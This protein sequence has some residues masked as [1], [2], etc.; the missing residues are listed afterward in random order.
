MRVDD[1]SSGD[2]VSSLDRGD[3]H[4][5]FEFKDFYVNEL[6]SLVRFARGLAND[7]QAAEDIVAD[8]MVVVFK[9]W[10]D[11]TQGGDSRRR[12]FAF[13]VVKNLAHDLY[14]KRRRYILVGFPESLDPPAE[15]PS[16]SRIEVLD[17]EQMLL[18]LPNKQC[19]V[20]MMEMAGFTTAEIARSMNVQKSTARTHL[21]L[22]RRNMRERLD[23]VSADL[24][25]S[26]L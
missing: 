26:G 4:E 9:R 3:Q 18:Q 22:A 13:G 16:D 2:V 1:R 7:D 17:V 24:K 20:L 6:S 14:R 11:L 25:H 12:S 10:N 8:A 5:F 19:Q 23:E 15:E 21:A